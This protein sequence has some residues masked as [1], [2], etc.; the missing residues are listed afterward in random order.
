MRIRV[1]DLSGHEVRALILEHLR[2]MARH[3][4]PQS[5]HALDLDALRAPT[6]TVWSAWEGPAL[7][8]CGALKQLDPTHGEI[9]SMRTADSA[10]RRGVAG[11]LLRHI[12]A[13]ATARGYRRLS[14]ETGSGPPFEPALRFYERNGFEYC[15]PFGDYGYDPFSVFMTR[16]L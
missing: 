13:E 8:G 12:V 14:L 11:G 4:P 9:K 1:D 3:S 5:V 15:E 16:T 10:L 6:V 2:R 7:L